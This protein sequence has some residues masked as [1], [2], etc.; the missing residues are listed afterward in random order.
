MA[1]REPDEKTKKVVYAICGVIVVITIVACFAIIGSAASSDDSSSEQP[2]AVDAGQ[3]AEQPAQVFD[4]EFATAEYRETMDSTGN[5]IVSFAFTNKTGSRVMV[6]GE[7][8][9]VNDQF[10]VQSLTGSV[11]PI[12]PGNTGAVNLSFGVSVQTTLAGVSDVHTLSA[13][14]VMRDDSTFEVVGSIPVS[15]TI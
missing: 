15:I 7:N 14:L 13:E 3:P 9:V 1:K 12:D 5:A 4:N 6:A 2:A 11:T 8:I 10:N